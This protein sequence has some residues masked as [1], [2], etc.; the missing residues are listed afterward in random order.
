MRILKSF[1][2]LLLAFLPWISFLLIAQGSLLRLKI[3]LV[4]ALL[5]SIGMGVLR[6]HRGLILWAGLVF[7][8][9]ATIAVLALESPWVIHSIGVL[10]SGTLALATWLSLLIGRPFTID[11][12]RE[13]ADPGLWQTQAFLRSN[14]FITSLWGAVF[15]LNALLAYGKA[16]QFLLAREQFEILSYSLLVAMALFTSWYGNRHAQPG[17]RPR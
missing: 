10:A 13:H 11:Y 7:F 4:V 12:A 6:L 17:N 3:G 14:K 9:F 5:L 15:T 8:V 2:R 16:N 1:L